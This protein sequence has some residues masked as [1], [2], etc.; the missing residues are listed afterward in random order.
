MF[1]FANK[2]GE[3]NGATETRQE[4]ELSAKCERIVVPVDKTIG[5]EFG[6][7]FGGNLS[8]KSITN[9]DRNYFVF[10]CVVG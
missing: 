9:R 10:F 4:N 7:I 8:A 5:K 6:T 1:A 2:I 3:L